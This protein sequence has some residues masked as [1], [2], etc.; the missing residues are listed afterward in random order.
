MTFFLMISGTCQNA[1]FS[2]NIILMYFHKLS[3][4]KVLS[5]TFKLLELI[6][7]DIK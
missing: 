5:L 4:A 3:T 1:F 7:I 6:L 2:R